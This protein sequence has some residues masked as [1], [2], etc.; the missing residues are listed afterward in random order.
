MYYCFFK[1]IYNYIVLIC[2]LAYFILKIAFRHPYQRTHVFN[3][4]KAELETNSLILT[5][6]IMVLYN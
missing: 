6:E 1:I 5:P 2:N 3:A 4:F